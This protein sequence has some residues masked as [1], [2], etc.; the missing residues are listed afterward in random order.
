MAYSVTLFS[1]RLLCSMRLADG[2]T[3]IRGSRLRLPG[4][5]AARL[6]RDGV[7]CLV[8]DADMPVLLQ[9]LRTAAHA[10]NATH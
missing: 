3:A 7:A 1:C 5:D 6:I 4:P 8:D 10:A 9:A 2:S